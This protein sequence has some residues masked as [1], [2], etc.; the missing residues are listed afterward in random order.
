MADQ[1]DALRAA[2]VDELLARKVVASPEVEAALR[3]VPRHVFA[4]DVPVEQAYEDRAVS[5]KQDDGG[6]A[7]SSLSQPTVVAVMLEQLGVRPGQHVLEIGTGTGYNA[8]LLSHLVGES[9]AVTTVDIDQDLVDRARERLA[10]VDTPGEVRTVCADGGHGVPDHAPYDRVIVTAGAWDLPPTWFDQLRPDG[11]LVVPLTIRGQCRSIAF[12][13]GDGHWRSRDLKPAFFVPLR[14]RFGADRHRVPIHDTGVAAV[15]EDERMVEQNSLL[16][17]LR[18][19]STVL[20]QTGVRATGELLFD[21]EGLWLAATEPDACWLTASAAA[22]AD[23]LVD[24]PLGLWGGAAGGMALVRHDSLAVAVR[25][26]GGVVG[27]HDA[28]EFSLDVRAWG[29][30]AGEIAQRLLSSILA[31]DSAGRPGTSRLHVAVYRRDAPDSALAGSH[32]VDKPSC[33]LALTWS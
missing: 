7:V 27:I 16:R 32:V 5:A 30:G 4:P 12:E 31:W 33:R 18:R 17:S 10:S 14:G 23:R 11:R 24:L 22:M 2:M 21:A 28:E 8:A 1:A 15:V 20:V 29:A 13:R 6:E 26:G 25:H 19:G 3:A 9:G